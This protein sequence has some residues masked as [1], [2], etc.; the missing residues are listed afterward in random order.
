MSV[1]FY[2]IYFCISIK[3]NIIYNNVLIVEKQSIMALK[4]KARH[5]LCLWLWVVVHIEGQLWSM[6][7]DMPTLH[8]M[9]SEPQ[10]ATG[11]SCACMCAWLRTSEEVRFFSLE[12]R[13]TLSLCVITFAWPHS[14]KTIYPRAPWWLFA[15]CSGYDGC[16]D[17]QAAPLA[18]VLFCTICWVA[19]CM[20][21]DSHSMS[22]SGLPCKYQ[23]QERMF[24]LLCIMLP[25]HTCKLR[26]DTHANTPAGSQPGRFRYAKWTAN[27]LSVSHLHVRELIFLC[28]WIWNRAVNFSPQI[29]ALWAD[30]L[31]AREWGWYLV[32]RMFVF[33]TPAESPASAAAGLFCIWHWK[34]GEKRLNCGIC[35]CICGGR[36]ASSVSQRYVGLVALWLIW[37]ISSRQTNRPKAVSNDITSEEWCHVLYT[38]EKVM[39]EWEN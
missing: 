11:W 9:M 26:N 34:K 35:I 14:H 19:L 30:V 29:F 32:P 25:L 5:R 13:S 10:R 4:W 3:Y 39:G 12:P 22:A 2:L 16:E 21:N 36:N 6:L 27:E 18:P 38:W 1:V 28:V 31:Y 23:H 17:L 15:Y 33:I 7:F 8:R 24:A 20:R 37:M